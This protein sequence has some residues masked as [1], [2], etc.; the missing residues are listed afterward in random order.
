MEAQCEDTSVEHKCEHS[1]KVHQSSQIASSHPKHLQ[2]HVV[3]LTGRAVGTGE[4]IDG[5]AVPAADGEAVQRVFVERDRNNLMKG[6]TAGWC[7]Q[8]GYCN[9]Y[10]GREPGSNTHH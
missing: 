4:P 10:G 6:S 7:Q 9:R 1:V 8:N 3:C 2:G 5:G